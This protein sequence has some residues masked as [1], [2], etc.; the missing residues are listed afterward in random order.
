MKYLLLSLVIWY[1]FMGTPEQH[2]LHLRQS[3]LGKWQSQRKQGVMYE[4]WI[5][6]NDSTLRGRAWI[7][8]EGKE[9]PGETI[10]LQLRE[11]RVQ[12]IPTVA[13]HNDNKPVPFT[14]VQVEGNSFIFENP[15]HDFPQRIVYTTLSA[16]SLYAF[17]EGNAEGVQK[18]VEFPFRRV[19]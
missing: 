16:D 9:Y 10:L 11:G 8:K 15:D 5:H 4:E 2:F 12:Y 1:L 14:L 19:P 18:K 3:I 7:E 6:E 17:I 13:N